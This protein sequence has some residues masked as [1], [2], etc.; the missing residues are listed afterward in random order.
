MRAVNTKLGKGTI[1]FY[2][3]VGGSKPTMETVWT[4]NS[5]TASLVRDLKSFADMYPDAVKGIHLSRP[6]S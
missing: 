5:L 1:E 2:W 4:N 3:V 6:K